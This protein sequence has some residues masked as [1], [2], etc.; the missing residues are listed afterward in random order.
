MISKE[1]I[2]DDVIC[3]QPGE[4]LYLRVKAQEQRF[5]TLELPTV[6]GIVHSM[7][8]KARW[9]TIRNQIA[10]PCGSNQSN[11]GSSETGEQRNNKL[12]RF[13]YKRENW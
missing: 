10:W 4:E 5:R 1:H 3:P 11:T 13:G 12:V 8:P 9:G 2:A 6:P 7:R